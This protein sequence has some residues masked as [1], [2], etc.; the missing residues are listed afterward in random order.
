[1]GRSTSKASVKTVATDDE[2]VKVGDTVNL[3]KG[4]HYVTFEDG[5][6]VT[7]R[8]DYVTNVPGKHTVRDS[9]GK[10]VKTFTVEAA[11]DGK[12]KAGSGA[13]SPAPDTA[14]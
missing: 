8:S 14:D 2:T 5:V 11:A 9:T 13:P 12:D 1:M 7:A 3:G 4:N 6:T 10:V